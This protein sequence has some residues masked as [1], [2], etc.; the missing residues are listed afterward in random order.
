MNQR[1]KY[2]LTVILFCIFIGSAY[3]VW[4]FARPYLEGENTE[5]RT[6][7]E[8]PVFSFHTLREYPG[9]LE[10]Y[11]NDHLPFRS[12]LIKLNSMIDYYL[13][14]SSSNSNV[15]L[16]KEGWL[17]YKANQSMDFYTGRKKYTEKEL[18]TIAD[19]LERTNNNLEQKGTRFAL[20]IAPNKERVYYEYMPYYYGTPSDQCALQ[21]VVEYLKEN[22]DVAVIC[23]YDAIMDYKNQNPEM[24]LYHKT[25]THWNDLGAYIGTCVLFDELNVEWKSDDVTVKKI[26][27]QPGDMANMLHFE[28]TLNPGETCVLSGFH[29]DDTVNTE[30]LDFYGHW[31]FVSP[32]AQNG[33]LLVCRDSFCTA[34]RQFLIEAFQESDLVHY[35]TFSNNLIDEEEPDIFIYEVCERNI[36]HLLE[37]SYDGG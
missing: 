37:Y 7:A 16:G 34:M 13:L 26:K 33:K 29:K 24:P 6:M 30:E 36:D 35:S 5:N 1:L 23:P 22:T 11:L 4:P 18:Q 17:F 32:S 19:N 28:K 15:E 31:T 21:Q 12:A 9:Q 14:K 3:I 25:D 27:D 20:F 8:A 10:A 2:K